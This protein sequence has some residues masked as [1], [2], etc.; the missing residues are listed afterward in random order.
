MY[1]PTN[2]YMSFFKHKPTDY[3]LNEYTYLPKPLDFET[4]FQCE[5]RRRKYQKVLNDYKK[6]LLQGMNNR[7]KDKKE[8]DR[9]INNKRKNSNGKKGT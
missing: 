7:N 9:N 2:K 3:K 1:D 4:E 8:R 5:I 6:N